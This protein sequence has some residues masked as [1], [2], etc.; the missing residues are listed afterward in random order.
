MRQKNK[1]ST[2]ESDRIVIEA[3]PCSPASSVTIQGRAQTADLYDY[4]FQISQSRFVTIR[5]L[6][7]WG[8]LGDADGR[9]GPNETFAFPN[10]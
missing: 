10:H 7:F 9:T 8:S 2:L 3:D 1:D 4:G 6:E 5:G